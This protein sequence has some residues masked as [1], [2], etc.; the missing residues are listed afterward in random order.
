MSKLKQAAIWMTLLAILLK[1]SGFLRESIV[2]KQFG[3]NEYTDGYLLAFSLIT[4]L[5]TM[6]SGGF[7]N[8]F[9]PLFVK[10]MKRNSPLAIK[11]ANGILN[12]T[13]LIFL[14]ISVV[15]VFFIPSI[16]PVIFPMMNTITE[17]VAIE[18][19]IIFFLFM[20]FVVLNGILDSYLQ[21][22]RSYVPSHVSKL[23]PTL[24]SALFALFFSEIWGIKSLAYGFIVGTVFGCIIQLYYLKKNKFSWIPVI[25]VNKEF[26]KVFFVLLVPSIANAVVGQVNMFIDKIFASGTIDGAVTYLNNA[27]L[28]VSIPYSIYGTTVAAI[29]F[30]LLSEQ[31]DTKEDFKRTLFIGMES[32]YLTLMPV[33]IILFIIGESAISFIYERGQFTNIDTKNTFVALLYYSPLIVTQGLQIVI[34]KALYAQEKTKVLFYV[35]LTT[36]VLNIILNYSFIQ[37]LGYVG[38]ALSSSIVSIY[39][40]FLTGIVMYKDLGLEE[41]KKIIKMF[42]KTAPSIIAMCFI[43]IFLNQFSEFNSSLLK[44]IVFSLIGMTIY[45]ITI[46]VFYREGFIRMK[47]LVWK[48]AVQK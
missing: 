35:S 11:N 1:L 27:S 28:L 39:Y 40:L 10:E 5:V 21:S 24:L 41:G 16:V 22:L 36:I 45:F 31:V 23:I 17:E 34:S 46:F 44:L 29:I 4:L 9:L 15:G 38:L 42:I 33:A 20:S 7:N 43:L 19:S 6:I 13:V 48:K 12:M 25:K 47:N 14:L 26:G 2:A 8:V 3:A 18:L 30:T 37:W 32:S